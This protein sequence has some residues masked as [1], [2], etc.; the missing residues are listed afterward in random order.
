ML[1]NLKVYSFVDFWMSSIVPV[2]P[3]AGRQSTVSVI[4]SRDC[5]DPDF[6]SRTDS[7]S[8]NPRKRN[9]LRKEAR[10]FEETEELLARES[11][12]PPRS[13]SADDPKLARLLSPERSPAS[14][15]LALPRHPFCSVLTTMQEEP[16]E[17]GLYAVP[18]SSTFSCSSNVPLA[19]YPSSRPLHAARLSAAAAV[20]LV[21]SGS[22]LDSA[23]AIDSV[24][25]GVNSTSSIVLSP[26]HFRWQSE[27]DCGKERPEKP[28]ITAIQMNDL[29]PKRVTSKDEQ[30][31]TID[32][33]DDSGRQLT[34]SQLNAAPNS[35]R[36]LT[37]SE[38]NAAPNNRRQL[39][40]PEQ[41]GAKR[42]TN[43]YREHPNFPPC[44]FTRT[45]STK[46]YSSVGDPNPLEGAAQTQTEGMNLGH[47]ANCPYLIPVTTE[48]SFVVDS[49]VNETNS[50]H[51][52]NVTT[53]NSS[54]VDASDV[55]ATAN[56][57]SCQL[58]R[59]ILGNMVNGLETAFG[60][61]QIAFIDEFD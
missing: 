51:D 10:N 44:C 49:I 30:K 42:Q 13:R 28:P 56:T 32:D 35:R 33:D 59:D 61:S 47:N 6:G 58:H 54:G 55:L 14:S 41:H 38:L 23:L 31:Q 12:T 17:T 26:K 50:L 3:P 48:T 2:R 36:Q 15:S 46:S 45:N 1:L 24:S 7:L 4:S 43:V 5:P 8:G 37:S 60:D 20:D 22:L 57:T 16:K 53:I 52:V 21:K 39:T 34:S 19:L 40:S 29:G 11:Q 27:T 9:A 18:K 25:S